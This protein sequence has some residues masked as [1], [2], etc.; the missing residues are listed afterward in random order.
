M[1][2]R[3]RQALT[4]LVT[5]FGPE[6][7]GTPARI[8]GF[9][10]DKCGNLRLENNVL[11]GALEEGIPAGLLNIGSAMPVAALIS[12]FVD[13]LQSHRAISTD[14]ALWAVESWALALGIIRSE[15]LTPTEQLARSQPSPSSA[16]GGNKHSRRPGLASNEPNPYCAM[17]NQLVEELEKPS[18][19]LPASA[20]DVDISELKAK[21]SRCSEY[22]CSPNPNSCP[23]CR[24]ESLELV[25]ARPTKICPVCHE[26]QLKRRRAQLGASLPAS[27]EDV[28]CETCQA[29]FAFD[30]TNHTM[31]LLSCDTQRFVE[32]AKIMG[33]PLTTASWIYA[34]AGK[35]SLRPGRIC[36]SCKTEFDDEEGLLRLIFSDSAALSAQV[37]NVH[38]IEDW[39][40]I[41]SGTATSIE[42]CE[43]RDQLSRLEHLRNEEASQFYSSERT[44]LEELG[45]KLTDLVK[46]SVL[47]GVMPIDGV[48]EKLLLSDG[49]VLCWRSNAQKLKPRTKD[50]A[51]YWEF[52]EYG[53]LLVTNQRIVFAASIERWQK[54]LKKMYSVE[55]QQINPAG[56]RA[57][58]FGFDGLQK[59]IGF[60]VA[61]LEST[62]L[63]NGYACPITLT[64]FDLYEML[65]ARL[66]D[67]LNR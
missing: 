51:L 1:D 25:K 67:G 36:H 66:S 56:S 12:R 46:K 30:S 49:E 32:A 65:Q 23:G 43:M 35:R 34:S 62:P 9:L 57:I 45:V 27:V 47:A 16:Q 2:D 39:R 60:I 53:A 5:R 54:P 26:G 4:E 18:T 8:R 11:M 7:L 48:T 14:A 10:A 37:G 15:A 55:I 42:E 13:Q 40:R 52:D 41:A 20:H 64:M 59:P 17:I 61:D 38:T 44:R 58:I 19:P 3:A 21:L 22:H 24:N 28:H 31:T 33:K 29:K 50:G 6:A 63:V